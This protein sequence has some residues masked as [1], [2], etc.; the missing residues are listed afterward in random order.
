[1][2][3]HLL[4]FKTLIIACLAMV[5][6][7]GISV[8]QGTYE[9]VTDDSSLEAGASVIIVNESSNV[10]LSKTQNTNNRGQVSITIKQQ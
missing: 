1:M 2:K 3:K 4:L 5:T 8:A 7:G 9:K 10:A 6:G